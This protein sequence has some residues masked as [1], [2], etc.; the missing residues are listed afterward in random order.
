MS[1]RPVRRIEKAQPFIEGAGVRLNRAFGFSNPH[2][3]ESIGRHGYLVTGKSL[4]LDNDLHLNNESPRGIAEQLRVF[5]FF[6]LSYV[7]ATDS[8]SRCR[9]WQARIKLAALQDWYAFP[10]GRPVTP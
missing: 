7:A 2:D 4:Y 8:G 6:N 5:G 9:S 3:F 10:I 1:I